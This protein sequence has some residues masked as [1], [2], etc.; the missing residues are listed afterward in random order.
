MKL[1]RV[2]IVLTVVLLVCGIAF[3][4]FSIH[5]RLTCTEYQFQVDAILSAASIASGEDPLTSDP[6]RAVIA[7]YGGK[8]AV[9]VPGN[10]KALSSYLR[11]DAAS[12]PFLSVDREKAL[13]LTVCSEAVIY[14]VP[15]SVSEDV[16]LVELTTMGRTFRIRTD[17]GNQW[18]SLL[19]CCMKGSYHDENIP[20]E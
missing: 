15:D 12:L 9:V 11:K 16:V 14:A 19:T 6:D 7:E 18:Q 4:V 3:L 5:S 20:L 17:G 10:F 1:V 2:L 8:R 13:K